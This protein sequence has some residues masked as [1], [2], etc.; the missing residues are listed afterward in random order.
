MIFE[1]T[2]NARL[3]EY[4]LHGV[5][6]SGL[7]VY[8]FPKKGFSKYYA[9]Y[10]TAYGSL[11]REF[12]VPGDSEKTVVPDGIAH[13][14]EHKMFEEPDG[15]NA[16]DRFAQT[17][18]SSNAFTSFDMTAY[19][20]SCTDRFY[21]NLDILLDFVNA[22]YYTEENVSK[23]QGIIGQEIRM[24]DDDPEWRALFNM[25]RALY[26][27][28]PVKIDIAGTVESTAEITPELLYKCYNTF[29]S[30][31]N[32][33]LVLVGDI[34]AEQAAKSVDKYV[35]VMDSKRAERPL[36]DEPRERVQ[37]V[38]EQK[39]SVS[40]PL[41][42]IGFKESAPGS[43]GEELLKKEIATDL[44]LEILFG[45]SS[46][47][48]LKLYEEGLIDRTFGKEADLQ[49]MYGYT[50]IGG[51]SRDPHAVYARVKEYLNEVMQNGV[52]AEDIQ[53][54]KKVLLGRHL[55][56]FN[57]V[58]YMGND[59]IRRVLNGCEPL[60]YEQVLTDITAEE[61]SARL[62]EHFDTAHCVLS[63]IAPM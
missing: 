18:A 39:L 48:Y 22:P 54:A 19:L 6:E 11:D 20:F 28:N 62:K 8:V 13:F 34:D 38:V 57:S 47:F 4:M 45:K 35:T 2:E 9:I 24:Y 52:C 16:F 33:A 36:A 14:L 58:E 37:E 41:F 56:M 61:L 59:F 25:L 51:E 1:K 21:E 43:T 49:T 5:H 7:R 42:R 15:S 3:G 12:I 53:R 17:G 31:A 23:E 27:N 63:V 46:A 32:M 30:P 50:A 40:I 60:G 44:L 29:Y 10:G 26:H 55:R